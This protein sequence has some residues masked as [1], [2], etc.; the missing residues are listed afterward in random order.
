M[1]GKPSQ[2]TNFVVRPRSNVGFV[3]KRL[4]HRRC[5]CSSRQITQRRKQWRTSSEFYFQSCFHLSA[6]FSKSASDCISGSTL[7]LRCVATSP[8]SS[9]QSGLFPGLPS[10]SRRPNICYGEE[11]NFSNEE[12]SEQA[13]RD[14]NQTYTTNRRAKSIPVANN[15]CERQT[16]ITN[17]PQTQWS[18]GV[19][20]MDCNINR[21]F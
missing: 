19:S 21:S 7:Y 4:W 8:A 6:C 11:S 3:E 18:S 1:V 16:A 12:S 9:M 14:A 2:A 13:N 10:A 5:I 15:S 17:L 20:A